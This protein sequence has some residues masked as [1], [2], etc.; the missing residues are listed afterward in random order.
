MF[1]IRVLFFH[2]VLRYLTASD[3]QELR[4]QGK[5]HPQM[6]LSA[7]FQGLC[8]IEKRLFKCWKY[9]SEKS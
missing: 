3:I 5:V 2:W 8:W 9:F 7:D 1:T 6:R 4:V